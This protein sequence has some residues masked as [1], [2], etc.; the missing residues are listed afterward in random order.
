M[1]NG[2][3]KKTGLLLLQKTQVLSQNNAITAEERIQITNCIQEGMKVGTFKKLESLLWDVM[4]TTSLPNVVES[5]IVM[6]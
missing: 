6:I 5:M 4:T 3:N 1:N 2:N